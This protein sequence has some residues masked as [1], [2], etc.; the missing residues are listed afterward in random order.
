MNNQAIIYEINLRTFNAN[1][2]NDNDI[3]D[4]DDENERK[5]TFLNAISRLDELKQFNIN[6]LHVLPITKT[7]KIKALGTAGSLYALSSFSELN[8]Q[9]SYA[10]DN[11]TIKKKQKS[12]LKNVINVTLEL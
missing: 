1:D 3:I 5:G 6:T 7:G 10:N 2:A 9:L 4:F 8:P 11:E 12:L